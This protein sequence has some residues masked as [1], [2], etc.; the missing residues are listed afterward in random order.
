[1]LRRASGG[2]D[3]TCKAG[4]SSFKVS[5]VPRPCVKSKKAEASDSDETENS[6]SAG[7]GVR[8]FAPLSG[9]SAYVFARAKE[10]VATAGAS[11]AVGLT[12]A[13]G[14]A[15]WLTPLDFK[16]LSND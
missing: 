9:A 15:G 1:M 8:V 12:T 16:E 5:D 10:T 6:V 7:A 11:G 14:R 3:V 2:G 13:A 4:L